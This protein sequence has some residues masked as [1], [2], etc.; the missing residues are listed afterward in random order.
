M[1]NPPIIKTFFKGWT[2]PVWAF[3]LLRLFIGLRL[4]MSGIEK[5][6][7]DLQYSFENYYENMGRMAEGITGSSFLPLYLTRFYAHSLGYLLILVGATVLLGIK[8]R[9]SLVFS[10]LLFISLSFGLMTVAG[11]E[12]IAFLGVHV[13]LTCGALFLV[14]HSRLALW[15]D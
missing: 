8:P 14:E 13:A 6:E 12:G 10:G 15:K 1:T 5:F 9:I 3:L 4:F 7:R 2:G 11:N